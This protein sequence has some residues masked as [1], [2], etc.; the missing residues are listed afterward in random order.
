MSQTP[1]CWAISAIRT[2][3]AAVCAPAVLGNVIYFDKF[4]LAN[5]LGN[6]LS[7]K[8]ILLTANVNTSVS[9]AVIAADCICSLS[10]F[11]VPN[12]KRD[13]NLNGPISNIFNRLLRIL[14]VLIGLMIS[15]SDCET[16]LVVL[17][18]DCV[19]RQLYSHLFL[20]P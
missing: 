5:G 1:A 10:N 16:V 6:S 15:P 11:P 19:Q 9:E 20:I 3:S 18:V 17:I 2:A 4:T 14:I 13:F 7:Y 8:F 12:N